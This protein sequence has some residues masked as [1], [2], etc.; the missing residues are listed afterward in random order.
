[1]EKLP[2][3]IFCGR[4]TVHGVY[5]GELFSG[6]VFSMDPANGLD[7]GVST[8][9]D[10]FQSFVSHALLSK[11]AFANSFQSKVRHAQHS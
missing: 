4:E 5:R 7:M 2:I 6:C 3:A 10:L 8:M 9:V 1:M 11:L